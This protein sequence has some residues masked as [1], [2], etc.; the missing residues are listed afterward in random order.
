[1]VVIETVRGVTTRV[2][3]LPVMFTRFQEWNALVVQSARACQCYFEF[4]HHEFRG[5]RGSAATEVEPAK[6]AD[7][8]EFESA[9]P[10]CGWLRVVEQLDAF[11]RRWNALSST[12]WLRVRLCRPYDIC[13]F[14]GP[15][16]IVFRRSRSTIGRQSLLALRPGRRRRARPCGWS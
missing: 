13:A 9:G 10:Q 3:F 1:M 15:P 8:H 16:V 5:W 7:K 6:H 2:R 14:G 11:A 4:F 12:R